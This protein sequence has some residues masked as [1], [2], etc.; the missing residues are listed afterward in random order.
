MPIETEVTYLHCPNPS[1]DKKLTDTDWKSYV[2]GRTKPKNGF[3]IVD[4]HKC[5]YCK[6]EFTVFD[7]M[8]NAVDVTSI[9]ESE[10]VVI[11]DNNKVILRISYK[12]L[13]KINLKLYAQFASKLVTKTS[14]MYIVDNSVTENEIVE[15]Y[16]NGLDN[17]KK[18]KN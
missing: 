3:E 16:K 10:D 6:F 18:L 17:V 1:C 7:T 8:L 11:V 4:L 9:K 15:T 14:K 13:Y 2:I 5:P 12:G